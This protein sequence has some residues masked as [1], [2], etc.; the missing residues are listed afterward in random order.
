MTHILRYITHYELAVYQRAGWRCT[1]Y[2]IRGDDLHCFLCSW[3]CCKNSAHRSCI[4][5]NPK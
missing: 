1:Y 3:P 5:T 2:G 4:G